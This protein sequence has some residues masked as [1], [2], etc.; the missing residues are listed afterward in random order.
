[1][2]KKKG[3]VKGELRLIYWPDKTCIVVD[4]NHKVT[5]PDNVEVEDFKTQSKVDAEIKKLGLARTD[6]E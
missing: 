2:S 3:K 6:D 1:M 5:Y 4:S